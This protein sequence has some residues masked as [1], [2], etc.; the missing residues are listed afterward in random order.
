MATKKVV[1]KSKKVVK[2]KVGFQKLTIAERK[3]ISK[4]GTRAKAKLRRAR[5]KQG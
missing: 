5:A 4:K 1:K 2:H 3:E